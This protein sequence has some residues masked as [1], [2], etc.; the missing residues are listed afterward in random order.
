MHLIL[1]V[2]VYYRRVFKERKKIETSKHKNN[3]TNKLSFEVFKI[4]SSKHM[5]IFQCK[6]NISSDVKS[7]KFRYFDRSKSGFSAKLFK[8]SCFKSKHFYL[9]YK[10]KT[11]H[12][13]IVKISHKA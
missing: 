10:R 9:D 2:L 11:F 6:C 1:F 12:E 13:I 4:I 3:F 5:I 8:L 7:E